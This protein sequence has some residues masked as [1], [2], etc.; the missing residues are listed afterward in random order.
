MSAD[1]VPASASAPQPEPDEVVIR[2]SQV[3]NYGVYLSAALQMGFCAALFALLR[4]YWPMLST[5]FLAIPLVAI[6]GVATLA[7]LKTATTSYHFAKSRLTWRTGILSR[8]AESL[9]LY[10][11]ADV[12][13][14]QPLFQRLFG[15]G[16]IV[17]SSADANHREVVLEGVPRPDQFRGWLTDQVQQT[18]RD[19]GMREIQ[20]DQ[21]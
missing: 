12:T 5:I 13:M 19:R 10:R 11:V 14:R 1:L 20:M 7:W 17:I 16:R 6:L 8:N 15:V 2:P 3:I 21:L 4:H 9:E 18:R